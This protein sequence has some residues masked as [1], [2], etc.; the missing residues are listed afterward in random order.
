MVKIRQLN[1]FADLNGKTAI[2]VTGESDDG[3]HVIRLDDRLLRLR[4][5]HL[6]ALDK[7]VNDGEDDERERT[8]KAP[9]LS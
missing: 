8:A 6:V 7:F 1:N 2:V 9:R 5:C 3:R 4:R